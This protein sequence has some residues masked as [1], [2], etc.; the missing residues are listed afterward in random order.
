MKIT[1]VRKM[2]VELPSHTHYVFLK[3]HYIFFVNSQ[4]T[5]ARLDCAV[6]DGVPWGEGS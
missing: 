6:D 3:T 2:F 4:R 1:A 5:G